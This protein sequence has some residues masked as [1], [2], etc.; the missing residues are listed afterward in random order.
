[1]RLIFA[2]F[3][4]SHSPLIFEKVIYTKIYA[5]VVLHK[6]LANEQYGF[7]S[8]PSTD[9]SSYTLIQD[10]LSATNNMHTFG[11]IFC[12]L[13]KA[14]DCVNHKILLSKLQHYGI[15]GTCGTLIKPYLMESYQRVALKDKTNTDN[16]SHRELVKHTVP[17]GSILGPSFFVL[18]RNYLPTVTAANAKVVL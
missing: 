14:F 2:R 1:V 9:S 12:Y 6:I 8:G 13:S 16:C 4:G 11:G 7:R 17:Q 3:L 10:V 18:C 15:T 5:H